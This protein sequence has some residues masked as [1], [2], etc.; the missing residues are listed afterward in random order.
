MTVEPLIFKTK[1]EELQARRHSANCTW[2]RGGGGGLSRAFLP[3]CPLCHF[4]ESLLGSSP[5]RRH[6]DIGFISVN[7]GRSI[8]AFLEMR[9]LKTIECLHFRFQRHVFNY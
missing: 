6:T 2:G 9:T 4:E 1:E 3:F 7:A 5:L 8:G